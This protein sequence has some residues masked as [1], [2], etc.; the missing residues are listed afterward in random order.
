MPSWITGILCSSD[1]TQPPSTAASGKKI[2]LMGLLDPELCALSI[3]LVPHFRREC[4]MTHNVQRGGTLSKYF[5]IA[6]KQAQ[7]L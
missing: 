5:L 4:I 3:D 1:P 2:M 6:I 7:F